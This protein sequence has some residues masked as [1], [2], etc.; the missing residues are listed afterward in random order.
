MEYL[1]LKRR[2]S[3]IEKHSARTVGGLKIGAK[4][5]GMNRGKSA[6][7]LQLDNHGAFHDQIEAMLAHNQRPVPD[8]DLSLTLDGE[9]AVAKL[10]KECPSVNGF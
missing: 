8:L 10:G 7:R 4:L 5:S 3:K 6:I 2:I 9:T 1:P